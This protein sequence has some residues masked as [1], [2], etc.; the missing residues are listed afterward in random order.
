MVDSDIG[1]VGQLDRCEDMSPFPKAYVAGL[2]EEVYNDSLSKSALRAHTGM[3]VPQVHI[4][5]WPVYPD[6]ATSK[7]PD[8]LTNIN[9]P[10]RVL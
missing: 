5:A 7:Y 10:S 3:M 2:G 1:S 9:E 4:A 8:P 6:K